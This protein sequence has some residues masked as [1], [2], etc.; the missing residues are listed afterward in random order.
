MYL[1]YSFVFATRRKRAAKATNEIT[2]A[3]CAIVVAVNRLGTEP[4]ARPNGLARNQLSPMLKEHIKIAYEG[5][6]GINFLGPRASSNPNGDVD[7]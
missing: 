2:N 1:K 3:I 6:S 4:G 7:Q 5:S